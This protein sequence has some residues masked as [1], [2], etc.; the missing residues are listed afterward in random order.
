MINQNDKKKLDVDQVFKLVAEKLDEHGI[1]WWVDY[2]SLL[3]CYR[4]GK[5]IEWDEDYDIGYWVEEAPKVLEALLEIPYVFISWNLYFS[6]GKVDTDR[7]VH[8]VCVKP[9]VKTEDGVYEMLQPTRYFLKKLNKIFGSRILENALGFII[10]IIVR[11][12]PLDVQK[13]IVKVNMITCIPVKYK[14]TKKEFAKT[15]PNKMNG[16]NVSIPCGVKKILIRMY[17]EDFMTPKRK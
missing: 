8:M 7:R 11:L 17:G 15:Y 9:H 5:R 12:F 6:V 10:T 2:G 14:G 3:G 16:T 13:M 1:E 4:E